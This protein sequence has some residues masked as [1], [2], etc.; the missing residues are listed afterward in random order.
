VNRHGRPRDRGAVD[1]S[2]Q[3]LF[4]TMAVL[5]SLLLV[6]ESVA[7]WHARN[8]F[9]EAASEGARVAAGFDHSCSD[10]IASARRFVIAHGGSW[11]AGVVVACRVVG[12][13][14][15]VTVSGRTPGVLGAA[16]GLSTSV[17]ARTPKEA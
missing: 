11:A 15:V 6:F 13:D 14:V 2:V 3:M 17:S 9:D 12:P 8:V 4:G 1:V 16:A 7:F 10:G 5:A